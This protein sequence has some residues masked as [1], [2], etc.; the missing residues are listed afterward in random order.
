MF[1]CIYMDISIYMYTD[2]DSLL[3]AVPMCG[4]GKTNIISAL[5]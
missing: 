4:H 5:N 1:T 3:E 2:Y